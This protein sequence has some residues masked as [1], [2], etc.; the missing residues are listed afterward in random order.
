MIQPTLLLGLPAHLR[1]E[2]IEMTP[3]A[4]ILSLAIET[5]EAPCPLCQ[6]VSSRVH[7]HYTRTLQDLPCAGKALRLL[8]QVR[9]FFCQNPVC[10]RK[11]FAERL[12]G[13]TQVYARRTRR[14]FEALR[15]LSLTLGGKAGACL[16]ASLG[17]PTNRMTL[18]R[19]LRRS[20][21]SPSPNAAPPFLGVDEF[22]FRRGQSYGTLLIDLQTSTPVDVLPDRRAST[23]ADWL[24]HHP[25][26]LLISRDRA[27]EFALGATQGAPLALQIADRFHVLRNLS[28]AAERALQP[29]RNTLKQIHLVSAPTA[30]A[31]PLLLHTRPDRQRRRL[32]AQTVVRERYEAVQKL[33]QEGKSQTE[34][35][36]RLQLNWKTVARYAHAETFPE[37]PQ[38]AA[39]PGILA[40]YETYLRTRFLEGEPNR[41]QLFR[42][43]VAQGYTG[44]RMTVTRFLLGLHSM[45]QQGMEVTKMATTTPLTP[46]RVVGL[47]LPAP[48]EL[49]KEEATALR[50]V[51]CQ[52]NP[53]IQP[54]YTLFQDFVQML[55]HRR[56]EELDQWLASAFHSGIPELRSFVHKLSQDQAAIQAG[57]VL[58]WNNGMVEGH[59][60]RVKFL[61]RSMY[62]RANFDLLR[63][64]IL[65]HRKCA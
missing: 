39:Q 26:T 54:L 11:I 49:T 31:S 52:V 45:Q 50:A 20:F 15:D 57:L 17:L 60:N 42:E 37:R 18:L 35:A 19:I 62:G 44:S 4:L 24:K 33:L 32:R 27:G 10:T 2:Q 61:K 21:S 23:F 5:V 6:H 53:R 43:I 25:G 46:R 40:A 12:P 30:P 8:V 14:C 56:G 55:R 3:Q 34:I 64:R 47:M 16:G 65:H 41:V 63:L 28:E 22:A 58:K 48:S 51:C 7:S 38:H 29:Y 59:V 1:L 13:L 36:K 9:R